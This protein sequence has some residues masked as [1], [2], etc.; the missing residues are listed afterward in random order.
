MNK[1]YHHLTIL[2]LIIA[3]FILQF[4]T[5]PEVGYNTNP[6]IAK[7]DN[8]QEVPDQ[9]NKNYVGT[10][11]PITKKTCATRSYQPNVI[12]PGRKIQ[13]AV[14]EPGVQKTIGLEGVT[15]SVPAGALKTTKSLS[16]TGLMAEDLPPIPAEIT[17]VTKGS[18]AT[19]FC[20]MAWCLIL[21][22][23]FPWH[24]MKA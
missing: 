3:S 17:N 7:V 10:E 4:C 24:T 6:A 11:N 23:Q 21:Q 19:G 13:S 2:L 5:S 18:Q 15:L 8:K 16:V 22:P 9:V 14:F 12:I 20:P 1:P